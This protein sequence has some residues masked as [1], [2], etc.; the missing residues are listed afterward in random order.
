MI[1]LVA[2]LTG[3]QK[4]CMLSNTCISSK[5]CF[6]DEEIA[7]EA[8][9]LHHILNDYPFSQGP[10]NVY[11]CEECGSWHFTSK[12]RNSLLDDPAIVKRIKDAREASLWE[13]R[14]K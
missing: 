5:R 11:Q 13:R 7:L 4:V 3:N 10:S 1:I 12:S 9:V 6:Y 2:F 8:L 14:L